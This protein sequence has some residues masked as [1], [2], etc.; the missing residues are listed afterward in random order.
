MNNMK[1]DNFNI[2]LKHINLLCPQ[3]RKSTYTSSYYLTKI[4]HVLSDVVTWSSLRVTC[5]EGTSD[6]H[7]TV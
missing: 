4:L 1:Q 2:I 6:Y 7:Y 5:L 3:I